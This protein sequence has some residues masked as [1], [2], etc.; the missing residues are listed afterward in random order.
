[1]TPRL[2]PGRLRGILVASIALN[3]FLVGLVGAQA[4]RGEQLRRLAVPAI[5]AL[6][7]E[8]VQDPEGTLQ[9]VGGRLSRD[10]EAVLLD[11]ARERM[12]ALLGVKADYVA[13]VERARAEIA[14]DLVDPAG[15][16]AAIAE[17]RRQRQR[18][19]PLLEDILLDAVPQMTPE[20]RRVLSQLRGVAA[21]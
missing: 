14:R 15:L 18:F 3:L 6:E 19:G 12:G 17:A 2:T 5:S 9:R 8:G 21:P 7:R 16:R 10:D 11:A 13:A 4:W 1:V 20:G